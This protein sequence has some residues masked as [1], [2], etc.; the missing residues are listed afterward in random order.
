MR[1]SICFVAKSTLAA[2]SAL[3]LAAGLLS[4]QPAAMA[5]PTQASAVA[6]EATAMLKRL[7]A[8]HDQLVFRG[9]NAARAWQV[10]LSPTEAVRISGFQLGLLNSVVD[11]PD[12]SSVKLTINGRPLAAAPVRSPDEITNVGVKIPHG[13]LLPGV[14]TVQVNV[15][16]THRVDCS[17]DATYELWALLDPARTGFVVDN[18]DPYAVRSLDE[19][20]AEP[21]AED[22][23]THIH[24]RMQ[25]FADPDSLGR[26]AHFIDALVRRAGLARPIVDVGSELGKGPGFDVVLFSGDAPDMASGGALRV[27][28]RD[29][30]VTLAR[31]AATNRL[32]LILSGTD[33]AD[34]DNQIAALD[35]ARPRVSLGRASPRGIVI[36][37]GGRKSFAELGLATDGFSGRHFLSS[38]DIALPADF[39]PSGYEK[40]RMLIDGYHSGALDGHGELIVRVN[41]AIVSSIS[42]ASGVAEQFDRRL[43]ELPLRFFHPGHNEVSIEG[44]T[45]SPLDQQCDLTA[46]PRD[47]RLTIAGTSELDFPSFAHLGTL[48]QIPSAIAAIAAPEQGGRPNVY[49]TNLNRE[50]AATALTILANMASTTDKI[51][52]PVV[53][54]DRPA[55][56][57]VPGIVVAPLDQLPD[58]LAAPL[59]EIAQPADPAADFAATTNSAAADAP[60]RQDLSA[61]ADAPKLQEEAVAARDAGFKER[62]RDAFASGALLSKT[63]EFFFPAGD[64]REGLPALPAHFLLMGAVNPDLSAKTIGGV[65]VPQFTH[66]AS[67]WLVVSAESPD[68][69][70]QGVERLIVDGQWRDLAGQAVS[71]DLDSGSLRS[72]QPARVAYVEPSSF[73]LSDVRPILGGILSD[74]I[75][76]TFAALL[77]L[78]SVLGLSTHALVRKSGVR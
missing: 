76:L 71:L 7:P 34:L 2:G 67:Q 15:A 24:V 64:R 9:E 23:A 56:G 25:D 38:V 14:N 29:G 20:A 36:E 75:L 6:P 27:L 3:A 28:G 51:E 4:T 33:E 49:L 43:L 70:K 19:L 35:K 47:A 73:A 41:D 66:D 55:P 40:A 16:L 63:A 77:A 31:D 37:G 50:S 54:L 65:A 44:I 48:P 57:D 26:A 59:R 5:A 58:Y 69:A 21:L 30:D 45:S 68:G 52:A 39:Y 17:V 78:V 60:K 32:V 42:M 46:M 53:R 10:Y 61:A 13:V 1:T 22:G 12:R 8:G 18:A 62:V 74:N 11:L 72:A